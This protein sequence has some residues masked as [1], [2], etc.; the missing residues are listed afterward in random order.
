MGGLG[1]GIL[2]IKYY[3]FLYLLLQPGQTE[4]V[5]SSTPGYSNEILKQ[6]YQINYL[7]SNI[8]S[9]YG[10]WTAHHRDALMFL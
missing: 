7:G 4:M 10:L 6:S 3:F 9:K 1:T 2:L 5:L 8:A